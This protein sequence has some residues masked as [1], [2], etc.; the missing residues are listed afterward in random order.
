MWTRSRQLRS[1]LCAITKGS[2][3]ISEFIIFIYAN[4]NSISIRFHCFKQI[5]DSILYFNDYTKI[6]P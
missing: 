2:R 6:C 5:R 4:V 1:E 3:S